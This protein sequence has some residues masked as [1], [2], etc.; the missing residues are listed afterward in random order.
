MRF[1][2][3]SKLL[4][5]FGKYLFWIYILQRIPMILLKYCGVADNSPMLFLTLTLLITMIM[6]VV[7]QNVTNYLKNK[8]W[9]S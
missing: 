3:K 2:F 9:C 7:S 5:W 1:C 6:S 8:I 4:G